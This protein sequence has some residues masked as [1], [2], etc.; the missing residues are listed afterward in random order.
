MPATVMGNVMLTGVPMTKPLSTEEA[1]FL[2]RVGSW[3]QAQLEAWVQSRIEEYLPCED[4]ELDLEW[5]REEYWD[6][7]DE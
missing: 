5:H 4:D 1:Y 3:D 7:G 2:V 6:D